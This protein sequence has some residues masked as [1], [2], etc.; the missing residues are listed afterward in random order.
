MA[1]TI[2][3]TQPLQVE[4][5]DEK[6]REISKVYVDINKWKSKVRYYELLASTKFEV[7]DLKY[8][9]YS[10][11]QMETLDARCTKIQDRLLELGVPYDALCSGF[12]DERKL[13][14][15]KKKVILPLVDKL[16][17]ETIK[18]LKEV[19]INGER[20]LINTRDVCLDLLYSYCEYSNTKAILSG[21][22]S[23]LEK[24]DKVMVD[25]E[26]FKG[27]S[28]DIKEINFNYEIRATGRYYTSNDN[29]QGYN[30]KYVSAF[31][32]Q[33]DRYLVWCD[34]SQ[35]DLR[36]AIA[37]FLRDE[38]NKD[39]FS[40]YDD[41]Y[42][43]LVYA[44]KE[45]LMQEFDEELFNELRDRYKV[46]ALAKLY[47]SSTDNLALP[48]DKEI[49]NELGRFYESSERLKRYE[50]IVSL[51]MELGLSLDIRDYFGAFRCVDLETQNILSVMVNSPIQMTSFS[52]IIAISM[53]LYDKFIQLGYKNDDIIFYLN[54]H[55][56]MLFSMSKNT[57]K[58]CW[59]F[60]DYET[61]YVDNWDEIKFKPEFGDYYKEPKEEYMK[62]YEEI[63]KHKLGENLEYETKKMHTNRIAENYMPLDNPI[64]LLPLRVDYN[65]E[66][67]RALFRIRFI[68]VLRDTINR[69]LNVDFAFNQ[70]M[71]DDVVKMDEENIAADE[72]SREVQLLYWKWVNSSNLS[73]IEE[74]FSLYNLK[75]LDGIKDGLQYNGITYVLDLVN[76]KAF[77]TKK[78]IPVEEMI[79]QLNARLV[80]TINSKDFDIPNIRTI[81]HNI[82]IDTI[83][84]ELKNLDSV[85]T[86]FDKYYRVNSSLLTNII[87]CK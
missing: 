53:K 35:I 1:L 39:L 13:S 14:M 23:K 45:I 75:L 83:T 22:R 73:N 46:Y 71:I 41:R 11:R 86:T 34:L 51:Y 77:K 16:V 8:R 69:S 67:Y 59:V 70:E 66:I 64:A 5:F 32:V 62:L 30:K 57:M 56:E 82:D 33:K 52:I 28:R 49:I 37:L 61:I 50:D 43:S 19:I 44:M 87:R 25:T 65:T 29:I 24:K 58:D 12:G 36:T 79:K 48:G 68:K 63:W 17:N 10:L 84:S 31:T 15:D 60:K 72:Y 3:S 81:N 26:D 18:P 54:R 55:D 76:G 85:V 80:I 2:D 74:Y 7:L 40:K 6:M 20:Q 47:K 38:T 9:I 42:E 21:G 27:D 78:E 4:K